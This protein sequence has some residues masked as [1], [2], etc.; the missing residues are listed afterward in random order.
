[1]HP[2]AALML[3]EALEEERRR[4]LRHPRRWV[5]VETAAPAERPAPR[6]GTIRLPGIFRLTGTRA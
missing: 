6:A 3:S 5:N 4:V 2:I 1:M